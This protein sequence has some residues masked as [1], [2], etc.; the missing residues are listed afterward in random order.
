M[1]NLNVTDLPEETMA[2]LTAKARAAGYPDRLSYVRDLLNKDAQSPLIAERYAYR[3]YGPG[4]ATGIIRRLSNHVNG[5]G[6]GSD[7]CTMKQ[8]QAIKQAQDL[9]RRNGAGDREKAVAILQGEFEE[10][11]EVSA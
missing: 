1:P 5:I 3:F 8:M 7:H 9:M 2:G 11:F 10:V 4:E 6:G